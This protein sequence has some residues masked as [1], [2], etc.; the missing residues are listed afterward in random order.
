MGYG[1]AETGPP[2]PINRLPAWYA[3]IEQETIMISITFPDGA[4]RQFEAP[5]NGLDIANDISKSLAKKTVAMMV[6]GELVDIRDELN[7]DASVKLIMRD[8]PEALELIRKYDAE[9]PHTAHE[10]TL[11]YL[12]MTPSEFE[13][14][15][16]R[17]R[18]LEI[19][20]EGANGW[21]LRFPPE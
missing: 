1:R 18:N 12:E 2:W 17:H 3:A 4:S 16:D 13:G 20:E 14:I 8:D 11:D 7:A 10:E 6:D 15:V 21:S 5:V 19:W 9:F